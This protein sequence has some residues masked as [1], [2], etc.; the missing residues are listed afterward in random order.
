MWQMYL[1]LLYVY[2]KAAIKTDVCIFMSIGKNDQSDDYH[3]ISLYSF[4]W[5]RTEH[6]ANDIHLSLTASRHPVIYD[7]FNHSSIS[8]GSRWS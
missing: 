1:S 7:V 8:S 5:S 6:G 3:T 4:F 2:Q